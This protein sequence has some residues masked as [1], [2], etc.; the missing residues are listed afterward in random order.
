M[1]I[2]IPSLDGFNKLADL[3]LSHADLL[4]SSKIIFI[5]GMNDPGPGNILP[6]PK[7][8][9]FFTSRFSNRIKNSIF[10]SN[11]CHIRYCTQEIIVFREDILARMRRNVLIKPIISELN[12][13]RFHVSFSLVQSCERD[14]EKRLPLDLLMNLLES[15]KIH[16]IK[17]YSNVM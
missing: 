6:R 8:P 4:E 5:P 12:D 15:L 14:L 17:S 2:L 1:I 10:T 13:D 7:I 9:D 3:L 11:P 16:S